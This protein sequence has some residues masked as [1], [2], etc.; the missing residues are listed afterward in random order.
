MQSNNK[1]ITLAIPKLKHKTFAAH[2]F[3][4]SACYSGTAYHT[5]Y[6]NH[7]ILTSSKP[8][9][10]YICITWHSNNNKAIKPKVKH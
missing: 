5:T 2:S 1:G 3:K 6:R 4:Y 7:K 8:K 10:K 9:S